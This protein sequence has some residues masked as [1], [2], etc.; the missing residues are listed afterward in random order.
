[1]DRLPPSKAAGGGGGAAKLDRLRAQRQQSQA[2]GG[3]APLGAANG[4][5]GGEAQ[6]RA[7]AVVEQERGQGE[8]SLRTALV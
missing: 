4:A 3:K 1:M 7:A 2:A 5:R 8:R 6:G